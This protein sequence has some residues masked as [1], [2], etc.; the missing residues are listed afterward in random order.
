MFEDFVTAMTKP[1]PLCDAHYLVA[2]DTLST[3]ID[4]FVSENP[5]GIIRYYAAR[6]AT[7]QSIPAK[8][9]DTSDA[10]VWFPKFSV[11]PVVV[12]DTEDGFLGSLLPR[13]QQNVKRL[14]DLEAAK[15]GAPLV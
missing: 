3:Y 15:G 7:E 4:E 14:S 6:K 11:E 13:W 9:I 12:K 10:V 8:L 1:V 2:E 5:E